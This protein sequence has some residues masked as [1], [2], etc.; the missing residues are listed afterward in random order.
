[1]SRRTLHGQETS[2]EN[3][4]RGN[5]EH[6]GSDHMETDRS[7]SEPRRTIA[8]VLD[9][10]VHSLPNAHTETVTSTPNVLNDTVQ[11]Q[12]DFETTPQGGGNRGMQE[13]N[14]VVFII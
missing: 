7:A 13:N 14:V 9:N 4:D 6:D 2:G 12:I 10:L 11:R 5:E 1:M 8:N 3:V